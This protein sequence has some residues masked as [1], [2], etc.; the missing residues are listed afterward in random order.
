MDCN[1]ISYCCSLQYIICC[2]HLISGCEPVAL[3]FAD[4]TCQHAQCQ[5][6]SHGC[7][8]KC[9]G[10]LLIWQ[11]N[12][13]MQHWH[14]SSRGEPPL[15]AEQKATDDAQPDDAIHINLECYDLMGGCLSKSPRALMLSRVF[16]N[17]SDCRQQK[18]PWQL[19]VNKQLKSYSTSTAEPTLLLNQLPWL[20]SG[21]K[22]KL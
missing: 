3:C 1:S 18:A 10:F 12:I 14:W 7:S 8:C 19:R 15:S 6:A 16:S 11:S 9:H 21:D 2:A 4:F 20:C 17:T 13:H 22:R 5:P